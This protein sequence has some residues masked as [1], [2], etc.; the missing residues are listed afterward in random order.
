MN[1]DCVWKQCSKTH[2]HT[3]GMK[4]NSI[5]AT[6]ISFC[7]YEEGRLLLKRILIQ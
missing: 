6:Y 2:T 7:L 3:P 5:F 4:A 1:F